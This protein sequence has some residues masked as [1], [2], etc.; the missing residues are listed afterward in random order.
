MKLLKKD[1]GEMALKV[2]TTGDAASENAGLQPLIGSMEG[3]TAPE[4][5]RWAFRAKQTVQSKKATR[6]ILESLRTG[7]RL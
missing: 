3:Y 4:A 7:E 2:L 1:V 6:N 5:S